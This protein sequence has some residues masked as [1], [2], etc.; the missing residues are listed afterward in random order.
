MDA[1]AGTRRE[2]RA[3]IVDASL[4]AV[5][6]LVHNGALVTV[7]GARKVYAAGAVAIAGGRILAV[8]DSESIV[9]EFGHAAEVIDAEGGL[10]TPGFIEAHVHLS[11]HLGRS[12]LPDTWPEHREHDH[13][14]PYWKLMTEEDAELSAQLACIEML[15]AGSTCFSDMSG[16]FSAEIQAR[17]AHAVGIRGIVS[18]TVWDLPPDDSVATGGTN[19]C[20]DALASLLERFPYREDRL[21]WAGVGLAGM[22][23]ASDDLLRRAKEL[24]VSHGAVMYMHQSFGHSDTEDFRRRAG[25]ASAVAHLNALGILGPDLHLV[26]LIRNSPAEIELLAESGTSLVHCPSASLRWGMGV[27]TTGLVPTALSRGVNIALG[28]DS[29][30]YS[31]FLDV[32]KQMYLAA[33]IHRESSLGER[34]VTAEQA[35]EMATINGAR[36]LGVQDD[37]GSIEVGKKADLVIHSSRRAAM[38]PLYDPVRTLVYATQSSAVDTVVIG[39][40]VVLRDGRCTLIDEQEV[41]ARVDAAASRLSARMNWSTPHAWPIH[42]ERRATGALGG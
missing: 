13:W 41:L 22:G 29:G 2:E 42:G 5:D 4:T 33:T 32:G 20:V 28:S 36:A 23:T 12:V 11:Q 25:G 31:D 34:S 18:E 40:R 17:A 21:T 6:L 35:V 9:R 14:L 8:G 24:A 39:G 1:A 37:L 26:H 30:N 16:R 10:I 7:D 19:Q 3:P 38:H 27:S 15:Q